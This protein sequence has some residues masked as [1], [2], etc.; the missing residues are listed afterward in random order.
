LQ[1]FEPPLELE[2]PLAELVPP[3][4]LEPVLE[5]ELPLDELFPPP[6]LEP[7]P[8]ELSPL[9]PSL[10]DETSDEPLLVLSPLPLELELPPE[11]LLPLCFPL[12]DETSDE[13]LLVLL[14]LPLELELLLELKPL[15]SS[16]GLG[17]S[18]S[19]VQEKMNAMASA[20][21]AVSAG[22]KNLL[23]LRVL[24]VIILL[25]WFN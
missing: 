10:E 17:I 22:A 14:P 5:L 13:L 24:F 7:P 23:P 19:E 2:L 12:E 18:I 16:G 15:V 1:V 3:L 6:E 21:L 25:L 9:C 11:E 8:D 20:M 4:E